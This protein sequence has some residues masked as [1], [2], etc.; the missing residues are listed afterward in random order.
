MREG[1][2][3]PIVN[4]FKK[5]LGADSL[6]LGLALPTPTPIRPNEKFNLD[7]FANGPAHGR[8]ALAGTL[9]LKKFHWHRLYTTA[10]R[11]Q[12]LRRETIKS[13]TLVRNCNILD[14][15]ST[16][17]AFSASVAACL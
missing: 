6:L 3:I 15:M 12:K 17:N 4:Q 11:P 8:S 13:L 16:R 5:I 14:Y 2:S 9:S 7:C 10:N 1:G